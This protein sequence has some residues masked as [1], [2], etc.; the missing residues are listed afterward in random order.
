MVQLQI[1]HVIFDLDGTLV[2]SED[3]YKQVYTKVLARVGKVFT[4]DVCSAIAGLA[5][6]GALNCVHQMVKFGYLFFQNS[7]FF[8]VWKKGFFKTENSILTLF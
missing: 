6:E 1:T 7:K 3:I 5:R 4:D 2:D 8:E